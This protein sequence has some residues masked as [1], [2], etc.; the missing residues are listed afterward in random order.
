[1]LQLHLSDQQFYC[2]LICVLYYSFEGINHTLSFISDM[3]EEVPEVKSDESVSDYFGR[4]RDY[5]LSQADAA[6]S[7]QGVD[8]PWKQ[9]KKQALALAEQHHQQHSKR[10]FTAWTVLTIATQN[11]CSWFDTNYLFCDKCLLNVNEQQ[12]CKSDIFSLLEGP[13]RIEVPP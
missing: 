3:E 12:Q 7:A 6:A 9:L 8:M 13:Y 11:C 10:W 5:W 1:M 4:T 2:L